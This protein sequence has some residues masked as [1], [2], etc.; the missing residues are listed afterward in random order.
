MKYILTITLL[1]FTL[2]I[3]AFT[4][5]EERKPCA[6]VIISK[7]APADDIYAKDEF[8][9]YIKEISGAT[10]P[11]TDKA[12]FGNNI[13]IGE[14]EEVKALVKQIKPDFNW[15]SLKSD[16]ILIL[17][18]DNN[19]ILA[20]DNSGTI[21]AVYTFLEEYCG[22]KYYLPE[23]ELI[24]QNQTIITENIDLSYKSPFLS[25]ESYFALNNFNPYYNLKLKLNG[26]RN[27]IPKE[28]GGHV[29]L[30][31]FCHTFN[32]FLNPDTYGKDHPE[33]YALKDKDRMA[34]HLGQPCLS[35]KEMINELTKNVLKAIEENP[36]DQII[37]V[38]Q[39]DNQSY[40]ECE[41]CKKLTEKYGHSGALLTVVNQVA[42]AVKEKYPDKFVETLAYQYTRHAPLGGIVPR[43]NVIIRLCSIECDFGH[44][45]THPNNKEFYKDLQDWKSICK[46][47]YLWD[48]VSNFSDFIIAHPNLHTIAPNIQIIA[49]NNGVAIFSEGD[50]SNMGGFF[51]Q[52]KR[53]IISKLLWNPYLDLDKE[54]K[55]FFDWYY[56]PA[57]KDMLKLKN[58]S[59][60]PFLRSDNAKLFTFA[61][62]LNCNYYN[63]DDWVN[64]F[65]IIDDALSKVEK[66]TKYYDRVLTDTLC[67][68]ASF[69]HAPGDVKTQVSAKTNLMYKSVKELMDAFTENG[70]RLGFVEFGN[71]I[72]FKNCMYT[73]INF[74]KEGTKPELCQNLPDDE[75][76][77][78]QD[79]HLTEI[80]PN[81]NL[82]K[83]V[84]DP[85]ASDGKAMWMSPKS[86]EWY[87]Q[88]SLTSLYF[89]DNMN[90]GDVYVTYK[91]LPG[92]EDTHF[93]GGIYNND[94]KTL[95][96]IEMSSQG[97]DKY[98][99]KK[100]GTID[101]I[102]TT[103]A[104][105]LYF[106]G[107]G[108][109][110]SEEYMYIDRV[111]II[112]HE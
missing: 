25:R 13:Y 5:T 21:Y 89:Y 80:F 30:L 35:N 16:G 50:Y 40:C 3:F 55:T 93:V 107:L 103:D 9:K 104:T 111:F 106:F 8:I 62:S 41:E 64:I 76:I 20:G 66:G 12:T 97:A 87:I 43:D 49:E 99:T 1:I 54:T 32:L 72:P 78:I 45:F 11:V 84:E 63:I 108:E 71:G 95:G 75:W 60:E 112:L 14:S 39:N 10:L 52:Y 27:T 73:T 85:T 18:Q 37:S 74:K 38:T 77:D 47:L 51:Q 67:M 6:K 96:E 23:E 42:D 91:I 101:F 61:D 88:L 94:T 81:S 44:D 19:L 58:A 48:Y 83:I 2:N 33:W 36:D 24:P 17:C 53:Y 110:E 22:V 46:T 98:I 90:K 70:E 56:G 68:Y 79:K 57:S 65:T 69:A 29:K 102:N 100:I 26:D 34:N 86:Y 92:V 28:L 31:G 59:A 82:S 4:I 105:R 15:D 7:D 109:R